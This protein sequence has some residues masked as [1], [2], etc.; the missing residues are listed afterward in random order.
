MFQIYEKMH[1]LIY[2]WIN[3]GNVLKDLIKFV[4]SGKRCQ[5]LTSFCPFE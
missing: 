2:A 4:D 1:T 3:Y 5:M